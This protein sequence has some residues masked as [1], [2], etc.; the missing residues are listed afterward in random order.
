MA[1]LDYVARC[2]KCGKLNYWQSAEGVDRKHLAD[3]VRRGFDLERMTTD[4]ARKTPWCDCRKSKQRQK[5][6]S[7]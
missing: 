1:E 4:D 7:L 3:V 6:L 2:L 5:E